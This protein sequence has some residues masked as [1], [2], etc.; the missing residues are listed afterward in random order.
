[1]TQKHPRYNTRYIAFVAASVDGRIAL[2]TNKLPDWISKEDWKFFQKMLSQMDAIIV[3]RNTY[4]AAA[5][6][7]RKRTTYVFSSRPNSLRKRGKVTFL[8]PAKT[9]LKELFRPYN[10]VAVLGGGMVYNIMLE[11]NLLDEIY[12]TLEP[13][14]FGRGKE[15]IMGGNR[16]ISLSLLSIKQLNRSGTLLL[17][18]KVNR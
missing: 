17:H 15:M 8:N 16:T 12:V 4:H 13:L 18:Y 14:I 6:R 1:M 3:G 5:P 11:K 7:L 2:S 10:H 9:D